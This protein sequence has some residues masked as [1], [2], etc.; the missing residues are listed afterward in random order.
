[1]TTVYQHGTLALLM[2]GLMDGTQTLADLL[3]NGDHGIG[4]LSGLD[5]EVIIVDGEVYQAQSSGQVNHITDLTA[6][7]PFASTHTH[8]GAYQLAFETVS[9]DNLPAQLADFQLQNVFAAIKLQGVFEHVHVRIA[10]KQTK[11][12]PSLLA[13]AEQQ[14]EFERRDVRGTIIGYF[15]PEVFA[16]ATAAGWHLHFLSDDQEFAGHLLGFSGAD[17]VGSLDIFDNLVQH[18]PVDD[19]A[20]RAHVLNLDGL[21]AGIEKAEGR[22]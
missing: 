19:A 17:I 5:G 8:Q 9:F 22:G 2:A 3:Q 13:V 4:T 20:F 16:G 18:L 21:K 12:Y 14:P 7:V 11:P 10:P 6:K 1:M 15:G